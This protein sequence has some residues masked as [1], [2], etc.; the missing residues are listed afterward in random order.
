MSRGGAKK[1]P[2]YRI[3]VIDSRK[4]RDGASL[5]NIGF[6]NP[7]TSMADPFRLRVN[8]IA[9]DRWIQKGAKMSPAVVRLM[10]QFR[11]GCAQTSLKA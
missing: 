2:F 6:Y 5:E 1:R 4:R 7:I 8:K 9:L 3:V 10:K 11:N